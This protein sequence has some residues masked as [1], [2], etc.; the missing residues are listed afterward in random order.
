MSARYIPAIVDHGD[1]FARMW[2]RFH[3]TEEPATFWEVFAMCAL[4]VLGAFAGITIAIAI[5]IFR[6]Q[7]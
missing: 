1:R 3:M 4:I 5:T 6:S 2:E 7:T